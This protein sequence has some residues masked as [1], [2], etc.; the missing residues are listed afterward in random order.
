MGPKRTHLSRHSPRS[1]G[2]HG[3]R[4]G[5]DA[6]RN[7]GG[8]GSALADVSPEAAVWLGERYGCGYFG[9]SPVGTVLR[10]RGYPR[11]THTIRHK[12]PRS[13]RG[14]ERGS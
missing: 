11:L 14:L 2:R 9:G 7:G 3:P 10:Q 4:K 5:A 6:L 13:C 8:Q 1:C 12:K